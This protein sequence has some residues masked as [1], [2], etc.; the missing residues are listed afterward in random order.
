MEKK[1]QP[2]REEPK[3][4][5]PNKAPPEEAETGSGGGTRKPSKKPTKA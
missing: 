3:A 2:A 4:V 1:N 5:T